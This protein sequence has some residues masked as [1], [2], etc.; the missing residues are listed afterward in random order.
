MQKFKVLFFIDVI[1]V[2]G[3]VFCLFLPLVDVLNNKLTC[4]LRL[5]F[6]FYESVK[7]RNRA[8]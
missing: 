6:P 2:K 4:N 3:S 8:L 7:V 5:N 1:R